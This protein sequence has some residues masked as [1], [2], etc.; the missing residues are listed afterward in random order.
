M[1]ACE[2]LIRW[3][4]PQLGFVSPAVFV[5]LAEEMGIVG[6]MTIF[7]LRQACRA[8][9]RWPEEMSVS[10]NLSAIDFDRST[11]AAEVLSALAESGLSP[12]RLEVEITETAAIKGK[13]RVRDVLTVLRAHGVRVALDDFGVGYS[14]LSHLHNLPLDRVKIDRS[15][16]LAIN[17]DT[18]SMKLLASIISMA[19]ALDLAVTVEGVEDLDTLDRVMSAGRVE[20]VQGFVFGRHLT[21][22][23]IG[24]L[25][26]YASPAQTFPRAGKVAVSA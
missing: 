16:I 9:A 22:E 19:R 7:V 8:C 14:G 3:N 6:D 11:L 12:H 4:H 10:V 21:A 15:F 23:Q 18:R 13:E 5:P 20:K 1:T 26:L 25:A 17:D 2:A 24:E